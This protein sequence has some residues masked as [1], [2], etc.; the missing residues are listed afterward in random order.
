MEVAIVRYNAGNICSVVN[1]LKRVG[2]IPRFTDNPEEL[3]S[4]DKILF[5]GQ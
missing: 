2:V 5:P 4:T 3:L 1:A